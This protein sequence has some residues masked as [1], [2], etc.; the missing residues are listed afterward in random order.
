MSV[1]IL[2]L[3]LTVAGWTWLILAVFDATLAET[4]RSHAE[5]QARQIVVQLETLTPEQAVPPLPDPVFGDAMVQVVGPGDEVLAAS[6]RDALEA[7]FTTGRPE[8][9]DSQ[10][11]RVAGIE[12]IDQDKFVIVSSGTRDVTGRPVVV[13]VASPVH[14]EEGAV[15][16]TILVGG[17]AAVLFLAVGTM[18]VRWAV[19]A[20]LTPVERLRG[21]LATIDGRTTGER[22]EVPLT[23]DELTRL[24]DTMNAM[25]SRLEQ[26]YATNKTFVSDASHEL[27][28]PLATL[29]TT[30]E[31]A[32]ADATGEIW[33]DSQKTLM[34]EVLRLQRM[35]DDLLTLSRYDAGALPLRRRACD[36]DD[37]VVGAV[38]R[39]RAESTLDVEVHV[40]PV[41]AHSDPER[42]EQVLRNLLDNASRHSRGRLR[43]SLAQDDSVARLLIDNDGDP[44][45]KADRERVFERFVRLDPTRGRDSGGSGLGLAIAADLARAHGGQLSTSEAEDGWCRFELRIPVDQ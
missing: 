5:L 7:P 36:L 1:A 11:V 10:L 8:P 40:D 43:V 13:V 33:R 9:G 28:S 23:G 4:A 37:L 21:Q 42:L 31:L 39:L 3:I 22:V 16:R 27:R 15:S 18:L 6:E 29:R 45:P 26:S 25:L 24:A 12:G 38:R 41:R 34:G 20:S 32:S 14:V 19:S 17:I 2:V 30:F 35:V 44:V